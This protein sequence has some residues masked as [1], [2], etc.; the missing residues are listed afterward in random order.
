MHQ[1]RP[2]ELLYFRYVAVGGIPPFRPLLPEHH[3]P[4]S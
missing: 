3:H 1:R 4:F 2:Q